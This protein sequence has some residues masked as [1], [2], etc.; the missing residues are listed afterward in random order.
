VDDFPV[1]I[2]FSYHGAAGFLLRRGQRRMSGKNKQLPGRDAN[3][4][5]G[6][7]DKRGPSGPEGGGGLD[8]KTRNI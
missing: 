8:K 4:D 5:A 2:F 6:L 1:S 3:G 7:P